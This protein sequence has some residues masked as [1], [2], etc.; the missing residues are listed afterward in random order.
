M[1]RPL[2]FTR[3]VIRFVAITAAALA[4]PI[5]IAAPPAHG[6]PGKKISKGLERKLAQAAPDDQVRLIV[7][8]LKTPSSI[9]YGRLHKRG[10]AVR[11]L[12]T[13]IQGPSASSSTRRVR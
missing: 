5:L 4:I 7:Q 11:R 6:G 8:T 9:H 12:H 1:S 3:R 10:G 13:S 2:T